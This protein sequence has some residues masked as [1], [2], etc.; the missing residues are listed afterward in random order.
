MVSL[1]RA[2]MGLASGPGEP[3]RRRLEARAHATAARIWGLTRDDL[4]LVLEDFP[5]MPL[6]EAAGILAAFD[7]HD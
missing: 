3:R 6:D 5:A 1:A 4:R 2:A 7:A